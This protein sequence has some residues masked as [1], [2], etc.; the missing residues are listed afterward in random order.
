MLVATAEQHSRTLGRARVASCALV[1][2]SFS[3]P[4]TFKPAS[5]GFAEPHSNG[6][7]PDSAGEGQVRS[8]TAVKSMVAAARARPAFAP[9]LGERSPVPVALHTDHCPPDK[10]DG[11]LRPPLTESPA[12][13][14]RYEQPQFLAQMLDRSAPPLGDNH[15]IAG[16][17]AATS[18]CARTCW[19]ADPAMGSPAATACEQPGPAD[20]RV[21]R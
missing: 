5:H 13:R 7:V 10:L 2:V 17:S 1:G 4:E 18:R 19:G 14:E 11:V 9:V 21:L 15:L 3:S 20:R 16:V 12:P 6:I 8:G